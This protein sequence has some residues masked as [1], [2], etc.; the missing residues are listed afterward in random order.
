MLKSIREKN[1]SE[2]R[3]AC[4]I[5]RHEEKKQSVRCN[6]Q[7]N[8]SPKLSLLPYV[9]SDSISSKSQVKCLRSGGRGK[10]W[11]YPDVFFLQENWERDSRNQVSGKGWAS[12][13]PI[14]SFAATGSQEREEERHEPVPVSQWFSEQ[15]E[16]K[17][18]E[19]A[20][21]ITLLHTT[22]T[23][24]SL[25]VRTRNLILVSRSFRK[26]IN[27]LIPFSRH[28]FLLLCCFVWWSGPLLL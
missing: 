17:R 22:D 2:E 28:S 18:I 20:S 1:V 14:I 21:Q 25:N 12:F 27:L 8:F 13:Q 7:R 24:F 19:S 6:Q 15:N 4:V 16:E 10:E 23:S 3:N 11:W 5:R 9:T 26:R